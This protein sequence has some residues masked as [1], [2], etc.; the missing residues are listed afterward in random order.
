MVQNLWFNSPEQFNNV[1]FKF[2]TY[3]ISKFN[4]I[5][6]KINKWAPSTGIKVVL[7]SGKNRS[8]A[9]NSQTISLASLQPPR[10]KKNI[11]TSK[12][13][14]LNQDKN[15]NHIPS[16]QKSQLSNLPNFI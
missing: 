4:G 15:P 10:V 2:S 9:D 5:Y 11:C 13:A 8:K 16:D 6:N 1:Y 14:S 7:I 3:P 12:Q